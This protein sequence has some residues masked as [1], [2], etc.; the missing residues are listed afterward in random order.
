MSNTNQF[1]AGLNPTNNSSLFRIISA[2]PQGSDIV[3]TWQT[4]GRR[5]NALQVAGGNASGNY[6]DAFIDIPGS[7]TVIFGSGDAVTN[8]TDTGGA[9]NVVSR[10]Y[11]V[12]LVP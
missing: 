3:V 2:V 1:L 8:H 10:F 11:R 9:T 7:M 12:R 5:T 6:T 4:A